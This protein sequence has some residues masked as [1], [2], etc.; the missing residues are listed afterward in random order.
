MYRPFL[1]PFLKNILVFNYL[2][3]KLNTLESA[4]TLIFISISFPGNKRFDLS[5]YNET[6]LKA[7]TSLTAVGFLSFS[8]ILTSRLLPWF[9]CAGF[10]IL[11]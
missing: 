1:H 7:G 3:L 11:T 2:T 9:L 8:E 4:Y 6:L 5:F 10:V